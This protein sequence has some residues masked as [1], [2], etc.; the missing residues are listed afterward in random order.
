MVCRSRCAAVKHYDF[1]ESEDCR[2]FGIGI[3]VHDMQ[4]TYIQLVKVG[5]CMTFL[6]TCLFNKRNGCSSKMGNSCCVRVRSRLWICHVYV[7]QLMS[8]GERTLTEG[9]QERMLTSTDCHQN[10]SHFA[11]PKVTRSMRS[12]R[13]LWDVLCVAN[14]EAHEMGLTCGEEQPV[15]DLRVASSGLTPDRSLSAGQ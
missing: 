2:G 14:H 5:W 3:K 4:T 15:S 9:I 12:P 10:E 6:R 13:L 7:L 11:Y 1:R 8:R